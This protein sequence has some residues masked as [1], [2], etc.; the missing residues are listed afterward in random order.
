MSRPYVLGVIPARGGSK[1]LPGKHVRDLSGKPLVAHT[2]E[3]AKATHCLDRVVLTT[4]S[5]EIAEIGRQHGAEVPWLRPAEL[6]QDT[7]HTPPVIEHAVSALE[8]TGG[9]PVD[10]VV[11]LQPTSPFR[12]AASI[13]E[14]VGYL[15]NHP[16]FDAVISVK[17]VEFPPFWMLRQVGRTLRPFVE[18][19]VDYTLKERQELPVLYQPNGAIYVTRRQLLREQGVLWSTFRGGQTGFVVMDWRSSIDIDTELDFVAAEAM[20][21]SSARL[22]AHAT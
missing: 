10:V 2:I 22:A 9:R 12:T 4:D 6:A 5:P 14:A 7:A 3:A 19:G 17:R 13:T 8:Q 11:T 20:A 16:E 15:L 21:Q 1:G 18:D